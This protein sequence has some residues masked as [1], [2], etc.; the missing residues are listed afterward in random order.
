MT[1]VIDDRIPC[2]PDGRPLFARP[3]GKEAWVLLLEKAF[4]K[5][6]GSYEALDG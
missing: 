1:V 4:A 2:R 6:W 3:N 5:L